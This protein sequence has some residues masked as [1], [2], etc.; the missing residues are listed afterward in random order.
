MA[1]INAG[2]PKIQVGDKG[3][4]PIVDNG[5]K[6]FNL[7]NPFYDG[8]TAYAGGGQ[9]NA[10]VLNVG[11]NIITLC[12]TSL[13]SAKLPD[14][15]YEDNVVIVKNTGAK[16]ANI[17]PASGDDLGLGVNVAV[18]LLPDC[19]LTFLA[20]T[21]NS[22]WK[23]IDGFIQKTKEMTIPVSEGHTTSN[24]VFSGI[25]IEL[26]TLTGLLYAHL[27]TNLDTFGVPQ[28]S[29]TVIYSGIV[30]L[31]T[32]TLSFSQYESGIIYTIYCYAPAATS[33]IRIV[34]SGGISRVILNGRLRLAS[35]T[36]V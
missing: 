20:I 25:N 27:N 19:S 11:T 31:N 35:Q 2:I 28:T 22:A 8:I 9:A 1:I 4:Y 26:E 33:E 13:D 10:T 34:V 3:K 17:Y 18:K 23:L 36:V 30:F 5:E 29:P 32:Q 12:A 15:F 14:V 16:I 6:K 21:A 7:V 24:T